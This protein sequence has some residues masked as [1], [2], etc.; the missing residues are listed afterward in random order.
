MN[1]DELKD[2]LIAKGIDE[3]TASRLAEAVCDAGGLSEVVDLLI[4][5]ENNEH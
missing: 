5:V 2:S 3:Q 1:Y 4:R